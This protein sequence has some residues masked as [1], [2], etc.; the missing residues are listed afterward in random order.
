MEE[1]KTSVKKAAAILASPFNPY[2]SKNARQK[3]IIKI[4][5]SVI[6]WAIFLVFF[7][8]PVFFTFLSAQG[9]GF[10]KIMLFY[11]LTLIGLVAW[12]A[13]GI[14]AGELKIKRTPLDWPIIGLLAVFI[15]SAILSISQRDS[16]VGFYGGSARSLVAV[17]FF[18]SFYYFL[19]SNIDIG[20]L[21]KIF[22]AF[23]ASGALVSFCALFHLLDI[24]APFF[25][26]LPAGGRF[27]GFNPLESLSALSIFLIA[28]LPLAVIGFAYFKDV[29]PKIEKK[30]AVI[31]VRILGGVIILS[32]F[33]IL[34]VL[35]GFVFWPAAIAAMAVVLMFLLAK[36][37]KSGE[38]NISIP[39]AIFLLSIILLV[40]GNF[41]LIKMDLP[42]EVSLSRGLSW[43]IAKSAVKESPL[44]GT[45]LSTFYY[46][47][48]RFRG[49]EFNSS[50]LWNVR[51]DNASGLFFELLATV[52]IAGVL[53][54]TILILTLISICF[55]A[56]TRSDKRDIQLILLASFAGFIALI[57]F[58]SLFSFNNS[59]II[60]AVLLS[61]LAAVSALTIYP[62]KLGVLMLSF[63]V[64]VK[65]ALALSAIFLAVSAGVV[66]LFIVGAKT[67]L[68]DVYA[69]QYIKTDNLEEKIDK[70][71]KATR[72]SPGRDAYY[73]ALAN[74]YMSLA[75]KEAA[76]D[77]KREEIINSINSA[78]NAAKNGVAA[79]P[80]KASNLEAL[81]LI[82]ENASFYSAGAL[83]LA[84][85]V[86]NKIIELEPD[87]PAPF[88][89][90]ALVNMARANS[91]ADE[92][93]KTNFIN[94]AIKKYDEATLKKADLAPAYYGKAIA[95]EKLNNLNEAI[96]QLKRA[97]S[98]SD[99]VDYK[100]ELGRLY[101]NRGVA[102]A[103]L[104]QTAAE[105][106]TKGESG[107]EELS[108][109][110]RAV[111]NVISRNADL[112]AAEQVFL[113]IMSLSPSH[114]N[115][116]Y[117]LALLYQKT[118]ETENAKRMVKNL[119]E[120]LQDESVKQAVRQ[121]FPGL[122]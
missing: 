2:P 35:G 73:M 94:E 34:A 18:I 44:F 31:A 117:S 122:Y 72:L 47:F 114:A 90:I 52:G 32:I 101:F 88:V 7:L 75:N 23:F 16:L 79:N 53:A 78:I 27:I 60:S 67:Y 118:G 113:N 21:K 65:Y 12:A 55:M 49:A 45:G 38:E 59:V 22:W 98:I 85:D 69:A 116:L 70:L 97:I 58:A 106:I 111:A 89:R 119:L 108:V 115:S 76:G 29:E 86:Y 64:S 87:N 99:N 121:Q 14:I 11:F 5:D 81:A 95:Y 4:L 57:I 61:L 13:K 39:L 68:A 30:S 6:F 83:E 40:I 103:S 96:E 36:I 1:F 77:D 24:S 25:P 93:E 19:V 110:Q 82:Y 3:R 48:S 9:A 100:F 26:A 66:I 42:T 50:P 63:K 80:Q 15:I 120:V 46:D 112:N 107:E 17:I 56:L 43:D 37:V 91:Q 51:F 62:E 92:K 104:A 71:G 33:T 41:N 109:E 20:K 84:E 8:V 105:N 10:D 102:Q 28:F 74:Q 54:V